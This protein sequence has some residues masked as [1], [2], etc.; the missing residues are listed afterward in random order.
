MPYG[1]PDD[2]YNDQPQ[3]S[4]GDGYDTPYDTSQGSGNTP[5]PPNTTA[6]TNAPYTPPAPGYYD[7]TDS[8][9]YAGQD[10]LKAYLQQQFQTIM[11]RPGDDS[12]LSELYKYH[13]WNG[14]TETQKWLMQRAAGS[15][16]DTPSGGGSGG[17]DGGGSSS[18]GT[19]PP[20]IQPW[21]KTF[22]APTQDEAT[23]TPGFQFRLGEGIKA[24][25]RSAASRGTLLTGGTLK[26]LT[27]YAQNEAS[28]EYGNV[29]NRKFN[30]YADERDNWYK[31]QGM[32]YDSART[33]RMDDFNIDDS[34][35]K[36]TWGQGLDLFNMNRSNT[37]DYYDRLFKSED[38]YARY[39]VGSGQ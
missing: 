20:A 10:D 18:Y 38:L 15:R 27:N 39:G 9:P 22:T 25:Q 11:G 2:Y 33:N 26:D 1:I 37:N 5:P 4:Y 31:N 17:Y 36:F 30:E 24:L 12:E 3:S 7:R 6:P 32:A 14:G 35:R 28:T 8:D 23:N 13:R 21:D 29:Y 16:H 34:T 19:A